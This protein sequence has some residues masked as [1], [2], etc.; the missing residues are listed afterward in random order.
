MAACGR[1]RAFHTS[2]IMLGSIIMT[3]PCKRYPDNS[4]TILGF[5]P[6][7][8]TPANN[9]IGRNWWPSNGVRAKAIY[10]GFKRP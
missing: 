9:E 4:N 3:R 7:V 2:S 6:D 5:E 10:R 1:S 8:G